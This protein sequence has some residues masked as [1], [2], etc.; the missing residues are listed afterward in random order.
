MAANPSARHAQDMLA[1]ASTRT[2]ANDAGKA[3]RP[4]VLCGIDEPL[5]GRALVAYAAEV[6]ERI[7][8]RLV[9]VHAPPLLAVEPR[10]AY[11]AQASD[12]GRSLRVA[13]RRLARLAADVG[14]ARTTT[15][16]VGYGDLGERL[17]AI[18]R[19]ENAA[20]ILIGS[21]A[22]AMSGTS[23]SLAP[24]LI[25]QANCPVV[26]LPSSGVPGDSI[27]CGV[28]GSPGARVALGHAARLSQQLGAR[29]VVANVVQM[30]VT[31]PA[32]TDG[33]SA[34][35]I[36]GRRAARRG[37]GARRPHPR[38]DARVPRRPARRHRRRGRRG[39]DRR[40]LA[41]PWRSQSRI[42]RQRLDVDALTI[43]LAAREW[44]FRR[45]RPRRDRARFA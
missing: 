44:A 24:R 17:R 21:H 23:G 8:G 43:A 31:T 20:L 19:R 12:E 2:F 7:D 29:L 28:D 4:V 10:I 26:A 6:V 13:A 40:R 16:H 37:W 30:P 22:S 15:V 18:A 35:R 11:A 45:G 34:D 14:I 3:V 1:S 25:E 27:V 5:V 32:R 38:G 33:A 39:A 36:P 41:R 9:L 42:A